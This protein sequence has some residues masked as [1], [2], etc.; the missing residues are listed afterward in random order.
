MVLNKIY[1]NY[2]QVKDSLAHKYRENVF[3]LLDI[4]FDEIKKLLTENDSYNMNNKLV[5]ENNCFLRC[6]GEMCHYITYN[7]YKG[8]LKINKKIKAYMNK[9]IVIDSGKYFYSISLWKL[10]LALFIK[11]RVSLMLIITITFKDFLKKIFP[12]LERII[13]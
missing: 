4:Y 2:R 6:M 9:K 8:L 13:L 11:N 7:K 3:D 12:Q 5:I 1:C 10:I